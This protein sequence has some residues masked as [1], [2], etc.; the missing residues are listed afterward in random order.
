MRH[1]EKLIH[2]GLGKT[3]LFTQSLLRYNLL[4]L[5][6]LF[7]FVNP[8][9]RHLHLLKRC[10]H[11]KLIEQIHEKVRQFG[12]S[13]VKSLLCLELTKKDNRREYIHNWLLF[14]FDNFSVTQIISQTCKICKHLCTLINYL[15]SEGD[16]VV[17]RIQ[18]LSSS[19][20]GLCDFCICFQYIWNQWIDAHP[21]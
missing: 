1:T 3:Y 21:F 11:H 10:S 9:T 13:Y 15:F 2:S 8:Y 20:S 4:S 19:S 7:I 12:I 6:Y 16:I 17:K 18:C 5:L 14:P